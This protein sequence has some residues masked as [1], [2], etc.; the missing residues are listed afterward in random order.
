MVP[1]PL[2]HVM[3]RPAV[4]LVVREH[5]EEAHDERVDRPERDRLLRADVEGVPVAGDVEVPVPVPSDP[6]TPPP[7]AGLELLTAETRDLM[8]DGEPAED[9]Q[10][11]PTRG[12]TRRS[13]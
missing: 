2:S 5:A 13:R 12:R 11:A 8:V 10:T 3:I 9:Q 6:L 4:V 1:N 7:D